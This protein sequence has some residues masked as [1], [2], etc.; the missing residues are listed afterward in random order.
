MRQHEPPDF[1]LSRA[2]TVFEPVILLEPDGKLNQIGVD[3]FVVG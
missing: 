1:L 2:R 3:S